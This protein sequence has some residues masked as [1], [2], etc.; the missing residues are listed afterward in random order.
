VD[1]DRRT[2][3]S[4]GQDTRKPEASRA[5]VAGHAFGDPRSPANLRRGGS[6]A[7]RERRVRA[8]SE[9]RIETQRLRKLAGKPARDAKIPCSQPQGISLEVPGIEPKS[10][11]SMARILSILG[12]FPAFSLSIRDFGPETSSL[13]TA[14]SAT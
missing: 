10:P 14:R 3:A 11:G 7:I 1:R 6:R 2:S 13:Q 4:R 5:R 8:I 12:E 9:R